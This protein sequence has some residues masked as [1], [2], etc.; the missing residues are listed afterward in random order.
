MNR[1]VN[2]NSEFSYEGSE[3]IIA[4]ISSDFINVKYDRISECILNSLH[5]LADFARADRSYIFL[6]SEDSKSMSNTHEW[7]KEGVESFADSL[8]NLPV[9]V[10]P[11][12]REK[13]FNF[14]VVSIPDVSALDGSVV[15]LKNEL[16]RE[17]IKSLLCVPMV[18]DDVLIGFVGFDMVLSKIDWPKELV[19]LLRITGGLLAGVIVRHRTERKLHESDIMMRTVLDAIPARVFWKNAQGVFTG[20]NRSFAQDAGFDCPDDVV[21]K[22]DNDLKISGRYSDYFREYD[23]RIITEGVP[24]FDVVESLKSPDGTTSW[25]KTNKVPLYDNS[26]NVVGMMGTYQDITEEV[27]VLDELQRAKFC[28]D[29]APD[30]IYWIRKDKSFLYVNDGACRSLGYSRDELLQMSILDIAPE[31]TEDNW[32]DIWNATHKLGSRIL[33][34]PHKTRDGKIFPVEVVATHI[35][36]QGQEYHISFARDITERKNAE[37]EK[38]QIEAE[39]QLLLDVLQAKTEELESIVYVSSHD[40]R[41]PLV[42]IQGFSGELAKTCL[43][44]K[45]YIDTSDIPEPVRTELLNMITDDIHISLGFISK[46]ADKMEQ[47]LKG[48]LKLSRIGR[49]FPEISR[50]DMNETIKNVLST[51][52]FQ[53]DASGA[54]LS[55]G[56][57]ADCTADVNQIDQLFSNLID[58]AVKYLD[59]SRKGVIRITCTCFDDVCEYCIS[60]NGIGIDPAYHENIFEIFHRLDPNDKSHGQGLGLTIVKRIAARNKG[61]IRVESALGVGS[62]FFVTLPRA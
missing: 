45:E 37:L 32:L 25:L 7:C 28:I 40:L 51:M 49:S 57:L 1:S 6:V 24:Q 43:S 56:P 31:V 60:D 20:C 35:E 55:V 39:R 19:D 53:I 61:R 26:G 33:E 9:D 17:S 2:E 30:A 54:D 14:E 27:S 41:T 34:G 11:W 4:E 42:N 10:F 58:N 47:L 22:T 3:R 36:F 18:C 29:S 15:K 46:S 44:M 38:L 48:L 5:K 62:K 16:L 12:F 21:G 50:I 59:P 8:Q 23:M 13:I 52:R